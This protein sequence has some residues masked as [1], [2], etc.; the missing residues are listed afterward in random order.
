MLTKVETPH[1]HAQSLDV[2]IDK[3]VQLHVEILEHAQRPLKHTLL[4]IHGGGAATNH[5]LVRRPARWLIDRGLFDRVLMP[6]R[7][8]NGG[9]SPITRRM[10]FADQA[11]DMQ[12]LLDALGEQGPLTAMGI[13]YG[14]PIALTLAAIDQR[15]ERVVLLASSPTMNE[16]AWPW[17]W[18]LKSGLLTTYMRW[19]YKREIGKAEPRIFDLDVAYESASVREDWALFRQAL[20]HMPRNR[21]QSIMLEFAATSDPANAEIP[22]W[23]RLDISVLQIIGSKDETWGGELSPEYRARFPNLRRVVIPDMGHKDAIRHADI[24]LAALAK[25]LCGDAVTDRKTV[26]I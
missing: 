11:E 20:H 6:D 25:E 10:T 14:G 26:S 3:G 8:G 13:S 18:L 17:N 16:M 24:F 7:R 4:F 21:L 9:S 23:V 5:T 12:R 19:I 1:I 15:V 2:A 22:P